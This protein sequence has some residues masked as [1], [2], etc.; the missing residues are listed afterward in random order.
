MMAQIGQKMKLYF[1]RH[2]KTQWNLEGRFQ[3]ANG[4]S[5]LLEESVR[6]LEKLGDYLK[7]IEFDAVFSS[8]L[9]V[10]WMPSNTTQQNL[11]TIFLTLS[12]S[13]KP[14]NVLEVLSAQ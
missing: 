2:G 14:Q 9:K 8:D 7:D 11:T 6:D 1:V 3:G 10:D 5:P 13:T 4:D 12:L